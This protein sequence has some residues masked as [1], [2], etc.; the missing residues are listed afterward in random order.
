MDVRA[1]R[2][3]LGMLFLLALPASGLESISAGGNV[4]VQH[5]Q[6]SP[7]SLVRFDE[8]L[9]GATLHG[10]DIVEIRWNGVP[11][12]AEE[13]ELLLSVDGGRRFSL[14]L[15]EELDSNSGWFLWRVPNL[16]TERATLALRMGI[17]EQEMLSPAGPVF[18]IVP[19]TAPGRV[20]LRWRGGEIW[21]GP[22]DSGPEDGGAAPVS[23]FG[24]APDRIARLPEGSVGFDLPRVFEMRRDV[25]PATVLAIFPSSLTTGPVGPSRAPT[26]FPR[27]I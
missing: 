8:P 2:G 9:A 24:G 26:T 13:M 15:T 7:A 11:P 16:N 5:S 14:R 23:S 12:S 1:F 20:A 4:P 19:D 10:G 18:R 6:R 27:R 21:Q 25:A 3:C 17:D 22:E